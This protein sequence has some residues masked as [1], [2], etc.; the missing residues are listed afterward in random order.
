MVAAALRRVGVRE[1][2]GLEDWDKDKVRGGGGRL[3][4]ELDLREDYRGVWC[5]V[6]GV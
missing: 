5:V 2:S 1:P 4:R 6:C 3:I